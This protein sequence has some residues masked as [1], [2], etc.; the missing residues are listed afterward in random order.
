MSPNG[1]EADA[2]IKIDKLL[3]EADWD[4]DDKSMVAT[5]VH[6]AASTAIPGVVDRFHAQPFATHA[7]VY[8]LF[9]AAAL[10][11]GRHRWNGL[12]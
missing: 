11:D 6:V 8:D 4:P 9:A 2:R 12:R 3:Q 1:S 10:S 5:E 7:P